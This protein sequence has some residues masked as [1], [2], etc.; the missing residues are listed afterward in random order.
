MAFGG[1]VKWVIPTASDKISPFVG[2]GAAAHLLKS[3]LSGFD[4]T[5]TAVPRPLELHTKPPNSL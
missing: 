5:S 3:E 4:P 1:K 2:A